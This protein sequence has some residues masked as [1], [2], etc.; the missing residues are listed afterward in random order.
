MK[1]PVWLLAVALSL[2]ALFSGASAIGEEE[3]GGA[4][5]E[6]KC[7]DGSTYSIAI[8][9]EIGLSMEVELSPA[10]TTRIIRDEGGRPAQVRDRW[11]VLMTY[12]DHKIMDHRHRADADGGFDL[13]RVMGNVPGVDHL[14]FEALNLDTKEDCWGTV[15]GDL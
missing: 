6:G 12:N 3:E 8:I 2:A 11:W 9:P 5:A 7:S 4:H 10:T 14:E 13:H 15:Q 1:R